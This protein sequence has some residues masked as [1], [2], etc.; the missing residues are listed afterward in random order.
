MYTHINIGT[1]PNTDVCFRTTKVRIQ[2]KKTFEYFENSNCLHLNISMI[3]ALINCKKQPLTPG[4]GAPMFV[5]CVKHSCALTYPCVTKLM[6]NSTDFDAPF[7]YNII[8]HDAPT[9]IG[10]TQHLVNPLRHSLYKQ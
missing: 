10:L 5:M 1:G 6:Q 7:L 8:D 3:Y 9:T 2:I 4:H